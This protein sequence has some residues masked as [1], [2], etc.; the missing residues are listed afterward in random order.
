MLSPVLFLRQE[1]H[2]V[3][4]RV[5]RVHPEDQLLGIGAFHQAASD[6]HRR[7]SDSFMLL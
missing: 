7:L 2:V 5:R 3:C 6:V 4:Q 1:W